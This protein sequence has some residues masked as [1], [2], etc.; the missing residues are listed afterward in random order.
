MN[1]YTYTAK[2]FIKTLGEVLVKATT[3]QE[4]SINIDNLERHF[5]KEVPIEVGE[6]LKEVPIEIGESLKE[7][8][9]EI[10]E[11]LKEV[12]IEVGESSELAPICEHG[13]MEWRS[14]ISKSKGKPYRGW[15]CIAN[16][17]S[18]QHAP[19]YPGKKQYKLQADH[20]VN[21]DNQSE[22]L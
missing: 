2:I 12:P 14:G 10:G 4:L 6:S 19:I 9:I 3:P 18:T 20:K 13:P 21:W 8:P 22:E 15:F 17:I 16:E 7:V 1:E 5:L 11:S